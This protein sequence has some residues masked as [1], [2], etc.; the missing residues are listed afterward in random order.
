MINR[1]VAGTIHVVTKVLLATMMSL[2]IVSCGGGGG[3]G[4]GG[5]DASSPTPTSY[6]SMDEY[7]YVNG[8][9]S[10]QSDG[11]VGT[12][13][14]TIVAVSTATTGKDAASQGAYYGSSLT[15]S[16]VGTVPGIFNVA[17]NATAF[18]S[19]NQLTK[20]ILVESNVGTGVTTGASLYTA[21]FGQVEITKD[22]SGK[23]HFA[24]LGALAAT[25]TLDVAGGV[26]DAPLT[27]QLT[28][29]DAH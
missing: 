5:G 8:G 12:R 13:P 4:G 28:I 26:A 21:S 17:P 16:F 9:N 18:I 19:A 24:S 20:P 27:M 7:V 3:G 6:W 15:F 25:K 23:L 11:T 1:S 14:V 22:D 10:A 2:V 29:H